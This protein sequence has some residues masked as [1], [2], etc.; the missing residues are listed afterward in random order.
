MLSPINGFRE[1][2]FYAEC[3]GIVD[4]D[5]LMNVVSDN[6]CFRCGLSHPRWFKSCIPEVLFA[7]IDDPNL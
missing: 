5:A 4:G 6:S 1:K 2:K 3:R 7:N